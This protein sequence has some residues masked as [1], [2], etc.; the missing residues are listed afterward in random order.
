MAEISAAVVKA[1]RDQT[2]QGMMECK[3]ALQE[4]HGDTAAA[5]DLLRKK[6]LLTAEKRSPARPAKAWSP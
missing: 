6:G 1:L 2:G 3:K 5:K 4:A